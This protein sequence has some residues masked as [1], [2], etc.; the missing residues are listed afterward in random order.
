[1]GCIFRINNFNFTD[2]IS[3]RYP[4]S[5]LHGAMEKAITD[6]A[7]AFKVMLTFD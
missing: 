2:L 3:H 5:E 4:F 7:E 6:K 1:L